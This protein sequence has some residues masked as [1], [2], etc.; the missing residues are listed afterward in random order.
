MDVTLT[1][2]VP[3]HILDLGPNITAYFETL[4]AINAFRCCNRFGQNATVAK[5]PEELVDRVESFLIQDARDSI[6]ED[7]QRDFQCFERRSVGSSHLNRAEK[8]DLWREILCANGADVEEYDVHRWSDEALDDVIGPD[9]LYS[10][11]K[12]THRK[13]IAAWQDRVA[14]ISRK[15][16]R[17]R[18]HFGLDIWISYVQAEPT[19]DPDPFIH[20]DSASTTVAYLTMSKPQVYSKRR[21][22]VDSEYGHFALGPEC[23][24][25]FPVE[26]GETPSRQSLGRFGRAMRLLGLRVSVHTSQSNG[27]LTP[28]PGEKMDSEAGEQAS[29][30][31]KAAT[32]E[33]SR[34]TDGKGYRVVNTRLRL[35]LLTRHVN[36]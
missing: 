23:G 5:L 2:A 3:V 8:I 20:K 4:P 10:E 32:H 30:R 28:V 12:Y 27:F 9:V 14:S 22:G 18:K 33:P 34:Y 17:V 21:Q 31:G 7:W 29:S 24:Y 36:S 13:R 35:T 16:E 25:G 1:Y 15:L 26:L 11:N 6:R 19:R